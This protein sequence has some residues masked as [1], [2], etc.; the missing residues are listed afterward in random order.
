MGL[1][2][3]WQLCV[4]SEGGARTTDQRVMAATQGRRRRAD[5]AGAASSHRP[6]PRHDRLCRRA[7]PRGD[8]WGAGWTDGDVRDHPPRQRAGIAARDHVQRRI[9]H[10]TASDLHLKVEP[11]LRQAHGCPGRQAAA[12]LS[13][14]LETVSYPVPRYMCTPRAIACQ[15]RFLTFRTLMWYDEIMRK[16]MTYF[17]IR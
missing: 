9:A 5:A 7:R 12:A 17:R 4:V 14:Q 6:V 15:I 13:R 16:I 1:V 8:G 2:N 3:C 11:A 10:R